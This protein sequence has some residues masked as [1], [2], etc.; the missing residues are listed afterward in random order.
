MRDFCA[1]ANDTKVLE[2]YTKLPSLDGWIPLSS[3]VVSDDELLGIQGSNRALV[4]SGTEGFLQREG[5][6]GYQGPV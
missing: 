5:L 6:H 2:V 3:D 1:N 4:K